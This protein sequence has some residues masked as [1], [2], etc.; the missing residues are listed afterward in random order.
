MDNFDTQKQYEK[1]QSATNAAE[2][3]MFA[4]EPEQEIKV[5][6]FLTRVSLPQSL[7]QIKQCQEHL[8]PIQ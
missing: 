5:Q 3:R 8:G 7:F 4:P 6:I 2:Q 1:L